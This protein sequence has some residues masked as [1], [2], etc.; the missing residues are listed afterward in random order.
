MQ[1]KIKLTS[2][3]ADSR[4]TYYEITTNRSFSFWMFF[5]YSLHD[6]RLTGMLEVEHDVS[7]EF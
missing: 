6:A 1:K 2:V 5:K 7:P 4:F 3:I